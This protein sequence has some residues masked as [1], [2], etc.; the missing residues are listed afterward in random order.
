MA[1]QPPRGIVYGTTELLTGSQVIRQLKRVWREVGAAPLD[2]PLMLPPSA[3]F[4]CASFPLTPPL[5]GNGSS[6]RSWRS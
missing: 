1:A 2:G 4:P 3:S 5:T 6:W